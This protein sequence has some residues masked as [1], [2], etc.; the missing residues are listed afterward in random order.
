M[1]FRKTPIPLILAIGL[2]FA[3]PAWARHNVALIPHAG[4]ASCSGGVPT[5][6]RRSET[7]ATAAAS[8]SAK[9]FTQE[10]VANMVRDGFG[11]ESGAKLIE[12]RGIDFAP[13]EDFLQSLKAAGASEAFLK[14]LRAAK[15]RAD[16]RAATP[17]DIFQVYAL[18]IDGVPGPRIAML[19][20]QRGIA[21]SKQVGLGDFRSLNA[22][23][24]I[25][26]AIREAKISHAFPTEGARHASVVENDL[27][28]QLRH[29]PRNHVI[30]L[31]LWRAL[32]VQGKNQRA[33]GLAR[34]AVKLE[35]NDGWCHYLLGSSLDREDR[36]AAIAEYREAVRLKPTLT[37]AH[38]SLGVALSSRRNFDS[39]VL[40]YQ[41]ALRLQPDDPAGVHYLLGSALYFDGDL[42][43]AIAEYRQAIQLVP[44]FAPAHADLGGALSD[45]HD[46]DAAILEYEEA[47]KLQPNDA[48]V[49]YDFGRAL[50]AKHYIDGAIAHYQESLRLQPAGR[51]A[52]FA[53]FYLGLALSGKKDWDGAITEFRQAVQLEP[54]EALFHVRLGAALSGKHQLDAAVAEYREGL[55]LDPS[56]PTAHFYLG[57]ALQEKKD[58]DGAVIAFREALRLEPSN[59]DAHWFLGVALYQ[60]GD[61]QGA[62]GEYRAAYMLHPENATYKQF[63]ESLLQQLNQ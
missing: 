20:R 1:R 46:L 2:V 14:A 33:L 18:V 22:S 44:N 40:E 11:D 6:E 17:L 42:D 38:L 61:L 55:R 60:K 32:S 34:D 3:L 35:P 7:A 30:R 19:I 39:A 9:P 12:Q 43:G 58:L 45:K 57:L 41:E 56:D 4:S 27:E 52:A 16:S 10:Q 36:D 50:D 5:A 31:A 54:A 8:T 13:T 47:L 29:S 21:F 15:P 53:H 24:D 48:G 25:L 49:H 59:A 23:P 37:E 28:V 63:Y 26:Q 62:L 51:H